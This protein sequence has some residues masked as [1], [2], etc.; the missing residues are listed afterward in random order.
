[1]AGA[2]GSGVQNGGRKWCDWGT[3]VP[4]CTPW[5]RRCICTIECEYCLT[6]DMI[7]KYFNFILKIS[8]FFA[9]SQLIK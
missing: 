8:D 6:I 2:E 1:M 4:P 3:N 9:Q 5:R 7:E